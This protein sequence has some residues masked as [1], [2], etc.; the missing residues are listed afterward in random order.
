MVDDADEND[1]ADFCLAD[2]VD[3]LFEGLVGPT[4]LL[5]VLLRKE[6]ETTPSF[7]KV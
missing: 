7:H 2:D 3:L 5:T 4:E 6:I 1:L